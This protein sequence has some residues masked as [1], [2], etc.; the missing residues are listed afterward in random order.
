MKKY[1]EP[2][3]DLVLLTTV[4]D[5]ITLSLGD[6]DPGEGDDYWGAR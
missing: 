1:E 3:M 2:N 6:K 4:G 5:V